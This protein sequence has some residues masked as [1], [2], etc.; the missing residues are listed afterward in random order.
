MVN[1]TEIVCSTL[2]NKELS[3]EDRLKNAARI[4]SSTPIAEFTL[5]MALFC[6]GFL[7]K[8]A[9][10]QTMQRKVKRICTS[11]HQD[12]SVTFITGDL[13]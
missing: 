12:G 11:I 1:D 5:P 13:I 4:K 7:E 2:A 9:K 3:Q 10:C 6:A 8:D